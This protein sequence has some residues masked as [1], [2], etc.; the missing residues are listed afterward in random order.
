MDWMQQV[1]GLLNTYANGSGDQARAASD[2]DDIARA[3]P[4]ER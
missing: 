3:A 1:G 4:R 2:F